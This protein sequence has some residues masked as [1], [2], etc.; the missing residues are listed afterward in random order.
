MHLLAYQVVNTTYQRTRE[1]DERWQEL[2]SAFDSMSQEAYAAESRIPRDMKEACGKGSSRVRLTHTQRSILCR[3]LREETSLHEATTVTQVPAPSFS[4]Y[5]PPGKHE[6]ALSVA[7]LQTS[8]PSMLVRTRSASGALGAAVSSFVP[9]VSGSRLSPG[10]SL[11]SRERGALSSA[12]GGETVSRMGGTKVFQGQGASGAIT[13]S[14]TVAVAANL[15]GVSYPPVTSKTPSPS[16]SS[17]PTAAKRAAGTEKHPVSGTPAVA[18]TARAAAPSSASASPPVSS[19]SGYPPMSSKA[20]TPFGAKSSASAA[21]STSSGYPPMSSKAPTPFGA[22]KTAAAPVSSKAPTPFSTSTTAQP[23]P[24]KRASP[25]R[26]S[27]YPPVS[28]K[29]PTPFGFSAADS[30]A[31]E[32][33]SGAGTSKPSSSGYPPMS[34]KAP[35]PFGVVDAKKADKAPADQVA[36][37]AASPALGGA[38]FKQASVS[39]VSSSPFSFGGLSSATAAVAATALSPTEGG[40]EPKKKPS[41]TSVT[42]LFGAAGSD[43]SATGAHAKTTLFGSLPSP[44]VSAPAPAASTAASSSPSPSPFNIGGASSS[45]TGM[46]GS[47]APAAG[48][49]ASTSSAGA[50]QESPLTSSAATAD[51]RSQVVEIYRIHNPQKLGDVDG[52][53]AK[54]QGREAELVAKLKKKYNN[55]T[56]AP[57]LGSTVQQTPQKPSTAPAAV[58][59]SPFSTPTKPVGGLGGAT[60]DSSPF[61][62]AAPQFGSVSTPSG[63]GLFGSG[64]GLGSSAPAPSPFGPK[65]AFGQSTASATGFG[66]AAASPAQA[67]PFGAPASG[68]MG[69]GAF[70]SSAFGA[71]QTPA[72]STGFGIGTPQPATPGSGGLFGG[73][74]PQSNA[75]QSSFTP[76]QLAV[77]RQW[78]LEVY[79]KHNPQQYSRVDEFLAKYRG[80]ET[81]MVQKLCQKYGVSPPSGF[82][83]AP[84]ASPQQPQGFGGGVAS[85]F[86]VASNP[87]PGGAFGMS[88]STA[89][90]FGAVGFGAPQAA[91]APSFGA[92]SQL[93]GGSVFGQPLQGQV[94]GGFGQVSA[95]HSGFGAQVQQGGGFGQQQQQQPSVGGFGQVNASSAG[96]GGFSGGGAGGGFGSSAP[97]TGFGTL[98]GQGGGSGFGAQQPQQQASFGFGSNAAQG[99]G[100]FTGNSFTHMRG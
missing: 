50:K 40:R 88:S 18:A 10:T 77:V 92:P 89:P 93:G 51:V 9:H 98:A 72:S 43:K 36:S 34:S 64:G 96:F 45:G 83:A 52:L 94:T 68:S 13:S 57:S 91:P 31:S 59:P 32:T 37:S 100:M 62:A 95:S 61:G 97:A 5:M 38:I 76:Q 71:P 15:G 28:T 75:A 24:S 84:G 87:S 67:S 90:V 66:A 85:A 49:F 25:S 65:P 79:Q 11:V 16:V 56:G 80:S 58:T 12:T 81:K 6:G 46:F 47:A 2:R 8:A 30:T 17:G 19:S 20:P 23:E 53:L 70:S 48:P 14:S 63:G 1:V 3:A 4:T 55:G 73:G 86:G 60:T 69:Q 44:S 99:S 41:S 54:Y 26:S 21:P 22:T 7:E 42:P 35:T 78:M 27:D 74:T 29:A 33:L 39:E 82:P